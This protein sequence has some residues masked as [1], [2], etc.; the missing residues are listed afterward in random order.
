MK[1]IKSCIKLVFPIAPLKMLVFFLLSLP[2]A[3]LPFF[4][5]YFEEQ[6]INNAA[7]LMESYNMHN[8]GLPIIALIITYFLIKL[9]DLLSKQY[10]EFGLFKSI[11]L[12]LDEKIHKKMNAISLEY[13]DNAELYRTIENGK[14]ATMF[15]VF[16]ANLANLSVLLLISLASI[17]TYLI[18]LH[19]ILI[20]FM[21]LVSAPVVVE[22]YIIASAN[23]RLIQENSQAKREMQY[24]LSLT[25][26]FNSAKELRIN[27]CGRFIFGKYKYSFE[28]YL[29]KEKQNAHYTFFINIGFTAFKFICKGA[30]LM[31]LVILTVR[32]ELSA[33]GFTVALSGFFMLT[34]RITQVFSFMGEMFQTGIMSEPFFDLMDIPEDNNESNFNKKSDIICEFN[35]VSYKYPC[36]EKYAIKN[37]SFTFCK[38]DSLAIVGVNGAGKTTIAKILSGFLIPTEG[39]VYFYGEDRK[40]IRENFI[41]NEISAVY[42]HF[43]KYKLSLY[44]NVYIGDTIAP[45][46]EEK[47][48]KSLQEANFT[49]S[50]SKDLPSNYMLGREFAGRE[51]SGGQWQR[52]A[53]ARSYYR[54][55]EIICMDEPTSAIDPFEEINIF[56]RL[57]KNTADKTSILITHRLGSIKQANHILVMEHGELVEQGDFEEL[58]EKQLVFASIWESQTQ[59]YMNE[60]R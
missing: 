10:M 40:N 14:A 6:I 11:L 46:E 24:F 15:I 25:S 28:E 54:D 5:L 27:G 37:V 60:G 23:A 43:G 44:D 35:N 20:F 49:D 32:G 38:G 7:Y 29:M 30:S 56:K 48:I 31:I 19:P 33:G 41:F 13:Y 12:V 47:I 16:T 17:G 21:I 34:D 2:T 50:Y 55:R 8:F 53:L 36:T 58:M 51:L 4:L 3:I 9:F 57:E 52:L 26:S 59:W 1:N 39:I 18:H 42:Q 45:I 22:K